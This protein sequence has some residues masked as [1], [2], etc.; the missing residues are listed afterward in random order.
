MVSLTFEFIIWLLFS[1]YSFKKI[2]SYF[3]GLEQDF[4]NG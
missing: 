2:V 4:E 3:S 1:K